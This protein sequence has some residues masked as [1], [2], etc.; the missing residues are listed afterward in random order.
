[1]DAFAR[2]S[3]RLGLG[4][5]VA[6]LAAGCVEKKPGV[7]GT[8]SLRVTLIDPVDPGTVEN[9]L[10]FDSRDVTIR[11]EAL[12]AQGELDTS[13]TGQLNVF[14]HYLGS[15]TPELNGPPLTT[16]SM[17]AGET[18]ELTVAL[19]NTYGPTFLWVEHTVGEDATFAT[20]TSPRLWYRNPYLEDVSRPPDEMALDALERSPLESKEIQ[21]N[22][23]RYGASG[24]MIVT[25]VYAQGYTVSDINCADDS[26]TPPCTTGDYDSCFIYTFS[27]PE[28]ADGG[29][30][31]RGDIIDEITG[32]VSEFNGLTEVNFPKSFV[33][34][35]EP[36]L[37]M[38]P[39]P[40]EIQPD[41]LNTRIEMERAESALI[42]VVNAE[43]CPLDDDF[44]TYAQWKL[45][46][47][48]GCGR[49]INVIST[50]VAA[51]FDPSNYVGQV[52]PRVVGTLRPVNI[53]SFNVWIMYPR[54]GDDITTP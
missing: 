10:Q 2:F 13:V 43:L 27:R 18:G 32:A 31:E 51:E 36:N 38:L 15:L 1:M 50:G 12:D 16:I 14:S 17:T 54:D 46:L 8:T 41:W 9:P 23:S 11:V 19:P 29:D 25:G 47:G 7:E 22:A 24:R 49:P 48:Q 52:I 30:L 5:L 40:I 33:N 34:P 3:S 44:E 20:G 39:E 21:I 6:M 42:A 4:C 53:G 45:D 35:A 26:G 37:A 28:G